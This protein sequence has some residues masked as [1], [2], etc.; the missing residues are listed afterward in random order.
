M[1]VSILT[2][3]QYRTGQKSC[4]DLIR[5]SLSRHPKPVVYIMKTRTDGEQGG[6]AEQVKIQ[7]WRIRDIILYN[8]IL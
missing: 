3:T 8:I 2:I 7:F 1:S 5:G 4:L 6:D